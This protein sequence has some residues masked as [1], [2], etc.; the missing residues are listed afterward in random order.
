MAGF[1][2]MAIFTASLVDDAATH[3]YDYGFWSSPTLQMPV[4]VVNMTESTLAYRQFLPSAG[5]GVNP[6]PR[7]RLVHD[8]VTNTLV[9][10]HSLTEQ[11]DQVY[12]H[13][14]TALQLGFDMPNN[15]LKHAAQELTEKEK[16]L[17]QL[18]KE[19]SSIESLA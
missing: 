9:S 10:E 15:R 14:M 2:C 16:E 6:S 19:I 11:Y 13:A 8:C 18:R 3:V 4:D 7:M 5:T 1:R 12:G 17:E